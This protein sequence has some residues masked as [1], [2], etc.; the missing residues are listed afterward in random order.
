MRN[1]FIVFAH[2][3]AQWR[4]SIYRMLAP[5]IGDARVDLWDDHRAGDIRESLDVA[6]VALL[7]VSPA[8][9]VSKFMKNDA[10]A[11]MLREAFDEGVT[12]QWV[13]V[14]EC[15]WKTTAV[16]E[17]QAVSSTLE[18]L[19]TLAAPRRDEELVKIADKVIAAVEAGRV[20]LESNGRPPRPSLDPESATGVTPFPRKKT[21][22]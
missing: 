22:R 5:G 13:L 12:V 16:A 1:L 20:N 4:A 18:P 21:K 3:D 8:F 10:L 7:L 14:T 2:E 17:F 11:T 6:D 15:A 19:D 9:L